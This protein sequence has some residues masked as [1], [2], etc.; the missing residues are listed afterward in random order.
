MHKKA[1]RRSPAKAG[2]WTARTTETQNKAAR[3]NIR[4]TGN[5]PDTAQEH[6]AQRLMPSP[7]NA[8]ALR[9]MVVNHIGFATYKDYLNS[10]MWRDIRGSVLERDRHKCKVCGSP[11]NQAHHKSY[12]K[13][14]MLGQALNLI[15]SLCQFC[16]G[17]I[18]RDI[19]GK[20]VSLSE[21]NRRLHMMLEAGKYKRGIPS[22]RIDHR[23]VPD[24]LS[25]KEIARRKYTNDGVV[26]PVNRAIHIEQRYITPEEVA[27][28]PS[29]ADRWRRMVKIRLAS[30]DANES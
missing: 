30:R 12:K 29:H 17:A 10:D 4:R 8:Y 26:Q 2:F 25:K 5:A 1:Q 11:A 27:A 21:A 19:C 13:E 24:R 6:C 9:M 22:P 14:V 18:E 7:G 15:V 16:H 3:R 20:K 28:D 23:K